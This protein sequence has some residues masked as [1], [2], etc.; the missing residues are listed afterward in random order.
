MKECQ[1]EQ[2]SQQH[3]TTR[4]HSHNHPRCNGLVAAVCW[5]EPHHQ[6]KLLVARNSR[7]VQCR[8]RLLGRTS[9][10]EPTTHNHLDSLTQPPRIQR[11][12]RRRLLGRA[13]SPDSRYRLGSG[14]EHH[15][16]QLP[17]SKSPSGTSTTTD[18]RATQLN[19]NRTGTSAP[20]ANS[21]RSPAGLATTPTTG[22]RSMP[23]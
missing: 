18:R 10:P 2:Q 12:C 5:A 4:T 20:P 9:S 1:H 3:T 19:T 7:M 6:L 21:S 14:C 8:R 16:V 11:A 15:S 22:P 23:C 17:A 13:S